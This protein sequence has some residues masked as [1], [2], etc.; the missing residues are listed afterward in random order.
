MGSH[1][2]I[3]SEVERGMAWDGHLSCVLK[4]EGVWGGHDYF[5]SEGEQEIM[6]RWPPLHHV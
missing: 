4:E 6:M 5:L 3:L 1:L 2:S